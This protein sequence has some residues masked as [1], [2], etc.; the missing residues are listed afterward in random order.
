MIL[1]QVSDSEI[2]SEYKKRFELKVG[3][4][5]SKSEDVANHLRGYFEHRDREQ[6]IVIL[7]NADNCIIDT[8]PL[9]TGTLTSSNVFP[10][11]IVKLALM[12]EAGAVILAHN[13]P[14]ASITPSQCDIRITEMIRKACKLVDVDVLDHLIV[15]ISGYM[16]F[17]DRGLL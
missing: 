10:R 16:S 6:F 9:F 7:L 15:T 14:S 8:V 13:H 11:E 12:R 5:L 1:S 4:R 3:S 17:A 2:I